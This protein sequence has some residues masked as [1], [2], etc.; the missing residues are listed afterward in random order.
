MNPRTLEQFSAKYARPAALGSCAAADITTSNM[1]LGF[2]H[3]KLKA[4]FIIQ[5]IDNQLKDV[6]K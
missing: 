6:R 1:A 5:T 3:F 4:Y 2:F